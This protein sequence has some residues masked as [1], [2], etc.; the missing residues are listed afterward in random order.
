M[1]GNLLG[2]NKTLSKEFIIYMEWTRK[3]AIDKVIL[4]ACMHDK[5]R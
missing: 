3:G 4:T 2:L 5:Y 1:G